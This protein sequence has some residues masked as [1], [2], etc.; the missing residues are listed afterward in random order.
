MRLDLH[1]VINDP[2]RVD[3]DCEIGL[4]G[5]AL[6]SV[7]AFP[8]PARASGSVVNSAGVL[9]LTGTL[10][11]TPVFACD[12]CGREF[13]RETVFPLDVA[14]AA[15]LTDRE[16]PDIFLLDGDFVDL[17]EIAA[18]AFVLGMDS[19]ILCSEDCMGLCPRCGKDLNDG[20]CGC[21]AEPDSRLAVLG[22]LLSD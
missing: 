18:D 7:V 9:T 4:E 16:N 2:G 20:P 17:D 14:L 5:R 13:E 19:K 6:P 10:S 1:T 11:V 15:E 3:F 12:R 21:G 8:S 22:Q